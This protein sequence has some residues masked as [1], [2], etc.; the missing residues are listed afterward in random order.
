VTV[1]ACTNCFFVGSLCSGTGARLPAKSGSKYRTMSGSPPIR[2]SARSRRQRQ[3]TRCG[4][5]LRYRQQIDRIFGRTLRS[6]GPEGM[7]STGNRTAAHYS[8]TFCCHIVAT[9]G[10]PRFVLV[11]LFMLFFERGKSHVGENSVFKTGP[12]NRS[13]IPPR[14]RSACLVPPPQRTPRSDRA[15][16][17]ALSRSQWSTDLLTGNPLASQQDTSPY[18]LCFSRYSL[19]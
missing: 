7:P 4:F 5:R 14:S 2:F 15:I 13:T 8:A 9:F 11:R 18:S 6:F 10:T 17:E 12:I 1:Q 16:L 3:F 19:S